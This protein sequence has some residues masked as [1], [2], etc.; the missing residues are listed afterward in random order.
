MTASMAII[1]FRTVDAFRFILKFKKN[2]KAAY[3]LDV[4]TL[5]MPQ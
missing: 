4:I 5:F 1:K 3:K 2:Y